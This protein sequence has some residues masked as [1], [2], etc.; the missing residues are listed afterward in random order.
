MKHDRLALSIRYLD[1][2]LETLD[3]TRLPHEE[4]WVRITSPE[5]MIH[6]IKRLAV[7]GAP[8]I[9]VAAA[10]ALA[11]FARRGASRDEILKAAAD[12]RD[13]RPTAV[14][15]M[16]AID[17]CL[18]EYE[19]EPTSEGLMRAALGIFDE[20]VRLCEALAERTA[21]FIEDGDG[22][23]THCNTGGLATA[24]A[25]TALA[26]IKKAHDQGKKIHVYIDETRP[27]GQG[28]RLTAWEL[29]KAGVPCTLICDNMAGFLMK[30]DKI[31]KVFVGAD[32]I[33]VNG[34]AANKIG[35]YSVAVLA[36]HH[37][38]PFYV[39]APS[40]TYDSGCPTGDEIPIEQRNP[41]EIRG[42]TAPQDIP[43]W[44]PAFDVTP[45]TLIT[46]LILENRTWE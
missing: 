5:G 10:L 6:E 27:L 30:Q 22:I 21:S 40:T 44:N 43:V 8:L 38:I 16:H 32:R 35:T 34:D 17:L 2:V 31:R 13:S 24:G 29:Q 39:V 14:N 45:K 20:D 18:R 41:D 23:L 46:A 19:K 33:A 36:R 42:T 7:R 11:D 4:R 25:G 1:G 26:G 15:L 12:L 37:R 28:S 9:G 3:Q